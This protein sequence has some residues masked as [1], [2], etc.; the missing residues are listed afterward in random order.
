[1][2]PDVCVVVP[3]KYPFTFVIKKKN[4]GMCTGCEMMKK[5]K[6]GGE[7]DGR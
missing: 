2:T 5:K 4:E 7:Q 3:M 6:D 1:M